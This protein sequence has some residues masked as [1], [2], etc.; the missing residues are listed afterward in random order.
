MCSFPPR[1][2]FSPPPYTHMCPPCQVLEGHTAA[3]LSL[4]VLPGG[5][6]L[7]GSGDSS[8]KMWVDGKCT[9][10]LKGHTDTVRGLALYPG[11]GFVSASHDMTL[12]VRGGGP[13]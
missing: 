4:I 5:A 9:A 1:T 7:S 8:I 12:K 2:C 10:T 13:C 11:V 6:L 3:V